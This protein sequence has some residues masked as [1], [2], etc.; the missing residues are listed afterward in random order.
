MCAARFRAPRGRPGPTFAQ[1]RAQMRAGAVLRL[2]YVKGRP[3]WTLGDLDV[4]AETVSLLLACNEIVAA[5]DA[6]FGEP[7]QTWRLRQ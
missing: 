3:A 5:G 7:S 4:A 6:L 2:A 1:A